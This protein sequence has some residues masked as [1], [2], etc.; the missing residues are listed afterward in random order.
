V[1]ANDR[2]AVLELRKASKRW[3]GGAALDG[4]DLQVPRG[5]VVGLVG[6]SGAGKTTAMRVALGLVRPDSGEARVF[7]EPSSDVARHSGRVGLLLDGPALEGGLTV[8]QNLELHA[9]RHGR[10]LDG[11]LKAATNSLLQEL[12]LASLADRRAAR[13]SQGEAYR[14]AIARALLLAPD[15]FVLDEP[16]AHLDPALAHGALDLVKEAVAE[17]GASALVSSHQ[18][19]ELERA[20][21]HLVLLHRGR[22][23]LAGDLK[24]LLGGV[25]RALRVAA[26]PR[27]AARSVLARHPAVANVT[28]LRADGVELFR[29]E[30]RADPPGV[31]AGADGD[32]AAAASVNAALHAAGLEVSLLVPER[33]T[34]EEL[35]R[36]TLARVGSAERAA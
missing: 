14:V 24:S 33:P 3:R 19:A 25:E 32:A 18:L 31:R 12:G 27:D 35:F 11:A 30:L 23:L 1:A 16:V 5:A 20:A 17:R 34:L 22:V 2:D 13:L 28:D 10:G 8:E 21:T 36:R 7:G 6:P 29:V 15:L 9:L 4:V 26:R